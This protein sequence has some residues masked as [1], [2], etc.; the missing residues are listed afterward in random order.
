MDEARVSQL[1]ET[2]YS[3]AFEQ[4]GWERVMQAM[5]VAFHASQTAT[6]VCNL[7]DPVPL[8]A[9]STADPSC[10]A[11][12][13]EHY[14]ALDPTLPGFLEKQKKLAQ[15]R[16]FSGYELVS[17]AEHSKS[18]FFNDFIL[19][20]DMAFP[21]VGLLDSSEHFS[22][23]HVHRPSAGEDF[24]NRDIRLL[25]ALTPHLNRGLRIYREMTELR[26]N[27]GLFADALDAHGAA[28][29]MLDALGRVLSLNKA[30]EQLLT[31]GQ[32]TSRD[33]RLMALHPQDD[34]A[35]QAALRPPQPGIAPAETMLRG[36]A[37]APALRLSIT[38]V[39]G[40]AIPLFFDVTHTSRA[41]FLVTAAPLGPNAENLIAGFGL[42][43]AEAEIT[44]LLLQGAKAAQIAA[45][46]ETS[47]GTVNTQ[48]K[49]IYAKLGVSGQV[50]LL[51]K[52]L[53]R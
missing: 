13:Q 28:T 4:D 45:V 26:A 35:L 18:E 53:G 46:R 7:P 29:L 44:L 11:S 47:I 20:Y 21:L 30:A 10:A 31:S 17:Y 9:A 25:A 6:V 16:A 34:A 39:N 15:Q 40:G 32:L 1:I 3:S 52:L 41:A 24:D 12:Y 22:L 42:T 51:V 33:G 27:A 23:F 43:R 38:P 49:Q 48:L 8:F 36:T 50:E 2:I 19:R 5:R 14:H 37:H